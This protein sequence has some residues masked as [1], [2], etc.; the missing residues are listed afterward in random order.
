MK[1]L[2]SILSETNCVN[3]VIDESSGNRYCK[4]LTNSIGRLHPTTKSFCNITCRNNGPYNNTLISKESER[5]FVVSTLKKYNP[6]FII[7][8]NFI[9]KVLE[10][11]KL[12]VDIIIPEEYLE[13]KKSLE[14][15]Q[16]LKGFKQFLLTG[17]IITSNAKRPLHDIDIV[18]WFDSLEDYL[19]IN[20]SEKLPKSIN[21]IK[22]DYFIIVGENDIS[23][24]S[25]FFCCVSPEDKKLYKSKW[26][27]LQLLTTP[28]DFEVVDVECDY[29]DEVMREMFL[30]PKDNTIKKCCG[31][32]R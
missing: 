26:F 4:Y 30:E 27:E 18:L 17:S 12:P 11:Y 22:T 15:L 6:F 9:H 23:F 7:N 2:D 10:T 19:K 24:S 16:E 5:K 29:F 3:L 31:G 13:I 20:V 21:G 25:L 8:K 32:N 1:I 28:P 14:S